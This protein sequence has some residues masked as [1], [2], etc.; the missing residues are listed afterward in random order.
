MARPMKM[1]A[2]AGLLPEFMRSVKEIAEAP[3]GWN[4]AESWRYNRVTYFHG[5]PF[6]GMNSQIDAMK[7]KFGSVAF[8]H[9]HQHAGVRHITNDRGSFFG[10][11]C[12]CLINPKAYAMRYG[13]RY[14]GSV[15]IGCG[16]VIDDNQ[17]M[18]IP[19]RGA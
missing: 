16:V 9:T 10:L 3:S 14:K 15:T 18:F 4:W 17:A 19:M 5:E 6:S 2:T 1:G 11:N 12:G 13:K 7:E 8:G